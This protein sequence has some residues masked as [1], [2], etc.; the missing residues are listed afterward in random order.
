VLDFRFDQRF[1]HPMLSITVNGRPRA[2]PPPVAT[3][4]DLVRE[5]ALHGKRIAVER[6]GEIVPKSRY[7]DTPLVEGDRVEI[8]GAVGGG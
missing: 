2:L 3:V 6:N 5:L 1:L 7:A 4:D 8:V